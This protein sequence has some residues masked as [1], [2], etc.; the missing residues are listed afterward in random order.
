MDT[1]SL[2]SSRPGLLSLNL[3]ARN[4]TLGCGCSKAGF[5]GWF[6]KNYPSTRLLFVSQN[7]GFARFPFKDFRK[8]IWEYA[9]T[10]LPY[11]T[12]QQLYFDEWSANRVTGRW[13]STL[14][15]KLDI[16]YDDVAFT[17]L[18]KCP[19]KDN[20]FDPS[21]VEKCKHFLLDQIRILRPLQIVALGIVPASIFVQKPVILTSH[22]LN[23]FNLPKFRLIVS[24]HPSRASI[25]DSIKLSAIITTVTAQ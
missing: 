2:E 12:F 5:P 18:V 17:N 8:I 11:E 22:N 13:F 10:E 7:P 24:P 9:P 19:F 4:C 14:L 1:S 15:S 20:N 25:T 23:L 21:A 16:T 3:T 6:G